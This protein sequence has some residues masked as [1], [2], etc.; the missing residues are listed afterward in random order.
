LKRLANTI[1]DGRVEIVGG[2]MT[3]KG[4]GWS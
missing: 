3:R 1:G 2:L 4:Q